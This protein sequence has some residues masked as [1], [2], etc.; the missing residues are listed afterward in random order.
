MHK[1]SCYFLLIFIRCF[2]IISGDSD[3]IKVTLEEFNE[4]ANA[5]NFEGKVVLVTGSSS[6]IGATTARLFARLGANVIVTGRNQTRIEQVARDCYELSPKKLT[7][8][9]NFHSQLCGSLIML[10]T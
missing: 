1:T 8:I 2:S 3:D 4:V 6:G 5:L 10:F 9:L 7:V